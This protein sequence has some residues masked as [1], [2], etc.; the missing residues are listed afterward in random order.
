MP[1]L[2]CSIGTVLTTLLL[3]EYPK[4]R[5]MACLETFRFAYPRWNHFLQLCTV[6]P[7]PVTRNVLAEAQ[8]DEFW[9]G[10]LQECPGR[11]GP[12]RG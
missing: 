4:G 11:N 9:A 7:S 10:I 8:L 5:V 12:P 3:T 1:Y 6:G 2:R